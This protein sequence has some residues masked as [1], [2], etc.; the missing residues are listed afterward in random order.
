ME[1]NLTLEEL[2]KKEKRNRLVWHLIPTIAIT[3]FLA[4]LIIALW[5]NPLF[6]QNVLNGNKDSG[7][8]WGML[9]LIFSAIWYFLSALNAPKRKTMVTAGYAGVIIFLGKDIYGKGQG[10]AFLLLGLYRL[11]FEKTTVLQ[12]QIPEN[13]EKVFMG[14][15]K[16]T[17]NGVDVAT[18]LP[19]GMVWPIRITHKED[20]ATEGAAPAAKKKQDPLNG[21]LTAVWSVIIRLQIK[22]KQILIFRKNI[23]DV[24]NLRTQLRDVV[25]GV[26]RE[27]GG[28]HSAAWCLENLAEVNKALREK[29]EKF[30][31]DAHKQSSVAGNVQPN[32]TGVGITP[33]DEP[34]TWSIDVIDVQA[35]ITFSHELNRAMDNAR[36][37]YSEKEKTI[38][39]AEATK[40]KKVLEGEGEGSAIKSKG[41]AEAEVI[42]QK[43]KQL[44]TEEGKL[45][46]QVG[47][48]KEALQNA[49]YSILPSGSI[50]ELFAMGKNVIDNANKKTGTGG[51]NE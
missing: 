1:A 27:Y 9:L 17:H 37:A 47:V 3:V 51:P 10:W 34:T 25:E 28:Q 12:M 14:P 50:A 24:E 23:G 7:F 2:G 31:K 36:K 49:D 18:V 22:G 46:A 26:A 41:F 19:E 15:E 48:L 44:E 21:R 40:E 16:N 5:N 43:A 20:L 45:A 4:I 13:P 32:T 33:M 42:G 38:V 39:D 6:T 35:L 30:V 29:C 8:T 11:E